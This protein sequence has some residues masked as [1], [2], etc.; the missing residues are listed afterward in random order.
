MI[1]SSPKEFQILVKTITI[2]FSN[3][4]NSRSIP[5]IP[6][7]Y[8]LLLKR[9][10]FLLLCMIFI[11]MFS[12]DLLADHM[13]DRPIDRCYT[14]TLLCD[15]IFRAIGHIDDRVLRFVH[16][17]HDAA[18][19]WIHGRGG[20]GYSNDV[21]HFLRRCSHDLEIGQIRQ[22]GG[23]GSGCQ[24]GRVLQLTGTQTLLLLHACLDQRLLLILRFRCVRL[25]RRVLYPHYRPH[26]R[27]LDRV[28]RRHLWRRRQ[29]R[30]RRGRLRQK[31]ISLLRAG[32]SRIKYRRVRQWRISTKLDQDERLNRINP[33][34]EELIG[35]D[36]F[37]N[38]RLRWF[39]FLQVVDRINVWDF[40]M[41][42]CEFF[43]IAWLVSFSIFKYLRKVNY[44]L[45]WCWIGKLF[46][47]FFIRFK[48]NSRSKSPIF[49]FW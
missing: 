26:F 3:F 18:Y 20:G 6:T 35:N 23:G 25:V 42:E 40:S 1:P 32:Y 29:T 10:V 22:V 30:D 24:V 8:L 34:Q 41:I 33:H 12:I 36:Y 14:P 4:N 5:D 49:I 28:D 44:E 13:F 19:P 15:R 16:L 7:W 48:Y 2:F 39:Q 31:R 17:T 37:W 38:F 47:Y 45:W 9:F 46:N 43:F 21:A 27:W 11:F